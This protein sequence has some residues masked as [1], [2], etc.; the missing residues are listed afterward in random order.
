MALKNEKAMG[1]DGSPMASVPLSGPGLRVT[2]TKIKKE[3]KAK[4]FPRPRCYYKT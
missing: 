4:H 1:P 3:I 2:R